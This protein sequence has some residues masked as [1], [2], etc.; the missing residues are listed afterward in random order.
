MSNSGTGLLTS[1][2]RTPRHGIGEGTA[3]MGTERA[4]ISSRTDRA[5]FEFCD[6]SADE[7]W[8]LI[9]PP[10]ALWPGAVRCVGVEGVV[11][12]LDGEGKEGG[13]V[14]GLKGSGGGV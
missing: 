13:E 14:R 7:G 12:E 9:V 5:G 3:G 4:S 8:W 6:R 1:R 2:A 11:S 10:A